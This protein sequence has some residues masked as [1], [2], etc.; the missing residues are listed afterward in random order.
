MTNFFK[1]IL[2]TIFPFFLFTLSYAQDPHFSQY[3]TS[4]LTLNPANT[5]NFVGPSRLT[6]NFRNQWQGIGKPYITGTASFDSELFKDREY[7]NDK[8]A[9]GVTT[10]YDRTSGGLLTSNYI[11][12]SLGYHFDLDDEGRNKLSVGFQG[13]FASKRLDYTKISF[14][15]QFTSNGFDLNLPSNQTFGLG[16]LSYGD[17]N[18]GLM[19]NY[20]DEEGSFYVGASAYHLTRPKESFLNDDMN[21]IPIRYTVH[22]GGSF[23]IGLDG[24]IYGSGLFMSQGNISQ[25]VIG[26]AYG[27]KISS[28]LDDIRV[29]AGAWYRNK[30]AVI[31]YLG[32][33]YN[34]FQFG[35]TYDINISQLNSSLSRY[36]SFEVSMIYVFLDK[37]QYRRFVPWY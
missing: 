6:S 25:A 37:S 24:S 11:A 35:L 28:T 21:R 30:D 29:F 27:K 17:I 33:I 36:R 18:A 13:S 7:K 19:Y 2:S 4:P 10:L 34:N 8:L 23:N 14:A 3:F 20:N 31:P 32:Y 26:L 9:I 15:D 22:S 1:I 12:A 5:G 16:T